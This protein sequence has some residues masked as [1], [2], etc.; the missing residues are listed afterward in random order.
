MKLVVL[1]AP[2]GAGKTTIA[3]HLLEAIS[4]MRFSVSATT[5]AA[6]PGERDGVDYHFLLQEEFDQMV[7]RGAFVEHEEVYP[8]LYYGTLRAELESAKADEPILLDIDVKG[9]LNVKNEFREDACVVFIKS[10]SLSVLEN[11]L[12]SRATESAHS[13]GERLRRARDELTFEHKFDHVITN[14]DLDDAV[15]ETIQCVKGFLSAPS[16]NSLGES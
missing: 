15:S 2:S 9:A 3:R 5:R 12:R 8:G 11:R 1:T 14:D 10:P 16:T 6:R 7:Q 4:P 13:V